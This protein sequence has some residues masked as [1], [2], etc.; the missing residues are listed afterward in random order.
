M[1]SNLFFAGSNASYNLFLCC[2]NKQKI[3][4]KAF[5]EKKIKNKESKKML[6]WNFKATHFHLSSCE[7]NGWKIKFMLWCGIYLKI[8][9]NYVNSSQDVLKKEIFKKQRIFIDDCVIEFAFKYVQEFIRNSRFMF[10]GTC[11]IVVHRKTINLI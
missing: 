9:S 2:Q 1:L 8:Y 6:W 3:K 5:N 10:Y 11:K 4:L 7:F